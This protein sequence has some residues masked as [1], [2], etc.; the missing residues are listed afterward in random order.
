MARACASGQRPRAGKRV[1]VRQEGGIW[2]RGI[3]IRE[4]AAAD[5]AK[6]AAY[7]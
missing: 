4:V 2:A 1:A 5:A 3:G 6:V 7:L